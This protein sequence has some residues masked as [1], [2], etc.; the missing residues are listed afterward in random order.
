M[1][2]II[3]INYCKQTF[4]DKKREKYINLCYIFNKKKKPMELY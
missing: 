3:I 4:N 1:I 2:I